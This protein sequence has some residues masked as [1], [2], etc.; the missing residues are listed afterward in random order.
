MKDMSVA[1]GKFF[2]SSIIHYKADLRSAPDT[3][4]SDVL[5]F[6]V[7]FLALSQLHHLANDLAIVPSVSRGFPS[8]AKQAVMERILFHVHRDDSITQVTRRN[9]EQQGH[10]QEAMLRHIAFFIPLT[11]FVILLFDSP[12][13]SPT[14]Q[15]CCEMALF[16]FL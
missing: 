6:N 2:S 1:T 8:N 14:S 15:L 9:Y 5:S 12:N 3:L 10:R 13:L 11:G 7:K 16:R 4:D